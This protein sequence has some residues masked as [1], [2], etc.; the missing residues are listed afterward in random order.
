MVES[1]G[2]VSARCGSGGWGGYP[3]SVL[4]TP[5]PILWKVSLWSPVWIPSL[6]HS[7]FLAMTWWNPIPNVSLWN[8]RH[9][10][11]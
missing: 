10:M 1:M 11:N 4:L 3:E 9:F 6:Q 5:M 8:A 7:T 2:G